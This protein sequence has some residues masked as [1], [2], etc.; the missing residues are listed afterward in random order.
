MGKM[1][2][3]PVPAL[4]ISLKHI[5]D[6]EG[7]R[8]LVFQTHVDQT[9]SLIALNALVDKMKAVADRL[10]WVENIAAFERENDIMF[11]ELE[12]HQ[13][14]VNDVLTRAETAW[15]M[16]DTKR[17]PWAQDKLSAQ[18]RQAVHT[19][20]VGIQQR[21]DRIDFNKRRIAELKECLTQVLK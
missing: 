3:V 1:E 4:G 12:R 13:Y 2:E 6:A 16:S 8:E 17:G 5:L 9:T 21:K 20:T 15:N 19:M 7:R 10:I 11:K 14:D 18:D